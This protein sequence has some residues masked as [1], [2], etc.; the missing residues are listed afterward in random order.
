MHILLMNVILRILFNEFATSKNSEEAVP[1]PKLL[2]T[3]RVC[4]THEPEHE[5]EHEPDHEA[6]L[7]PTHI[8]HGRAL[9]NNY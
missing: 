9:C 8:V 4:V 2:C 1:E 6:R 3:P 7:L 5:P